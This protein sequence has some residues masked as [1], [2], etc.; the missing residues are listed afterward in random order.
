MTYTE[1]NFEEH[2]EKFFKSKSFNSY[3]SEEFYNKKFCLVP[4]D[5]FTFLEKT[6]TKKLDLLKKQYGDD[7]E[8]KFINYLYKEIDERGVI[9][10]L[11][12][13]I[14]N[15]GQKI[16][17]IYFEPNS[18]LNKDLE[19]KYKNNIFSIIRQLKFL[20][21]T[22]HSIDI[23]LFVNGLPIITIELKNSL[24]GQSAI[25]AVKQYIEDRNPNDKIFNFNRCIVHFAV[26][27]EEVFMTTAIKGKNTKFLPFNKDIENPIN[28]SGHKA[29]YLWEEVLTQN[30]ILN[31]IQ[32]Y[33]FIQEREEGS[34]DDKEIKYDLIFP[35]YHQ[36]NVINKIKSDIV[37]NDVGKKYLIQHTTGSGKSLTIAWLT[38]KLS[39]LF[40]SKDSLNKIFDTVIVLT[41][42][43]VLDKQLRNT[44][45]QLQQVEGVVNPVTKDSQEL[46]KFI[47]SGKNIIVSTIQKFPVI[48]SSINK[49]KNK[50]FAVVIDEVH[51]SQS[52][53]FSDHLVKSLSKN[54]L[55]NFEEGSPDDDLT[56]IDTYILNELSKLKDLSHISFFGFSGTP[57]KTTLEIFGTKN[58]ETGEIEAFHTYSMKQSIFEGFTL[59]VLKNYI[60]YERFFNISKKIEDEKILPTGKTKSLLVKYVDLHPSTIEEKT[61][62]IIDHFLNY[63]IKKINNTAKAMIVTRSRLHCVKYK[64]EFDK[65]LEKLGNPFKSLV[66]FT[67]KITDKDLEID[68]T[69][70]SMNGFADKITEEKFKDDDNKILIVNNKFQTGFDEPLLHTMYVD[71]KLSGIQSVQTLSRLN[72]SSKGKF[73]TTV[74][75]FVNNAAITKD[76]FQPYFQSLILSEETDPNEIYKIERNIRKF[77]IIDQQ[78]IDEY[79]KIYIDKKSKQELLQPILDTTIKN[80]KEA[81]NKEKK[82]EFKSLIHLFVKTYSFIKQISNFTDIDL[83]KFYIFVFDLLKK[84]PKK[85]NENYIVENF[86]DLNFLKISKKFQ[87]QIVLDD[88]DGTVRPGINTETTIKEEEFS[89]LDKIIDEINKRFNADFSDE[90]K[91]NLNDMQSDIKNNLNWLNIENDQTTETNK[92][93][94]FNKLFKEKIT[95]LASKNFSLYNKLQDEETKQIIKNKI[96]TEIN[97]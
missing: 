53:K 45:L 69:E 12:K 25:D 86:V 52:G 76:S 9:D 29:S 64:L 22:Q 73:D 46:K 80:F 56:D 85:D 7:F 65:Q 27:N 91:S 39:N 28:P 47:E 16:D 2:I 57:K 42:R 71:K 49:E 72:R 51:S 4:K 24:T 60:T 35:R 48:S 89:T 68:Y 20:E 62:I 55:D 1:R 54:D 43:K 96:Y 95:E 19:A 93:L 97:L 30:N 6:Q 3:K 63:S 58:K 41:D 44:I 11:R 92:R 84:I 88:T 34:K 33:V 77:N 94:I 79:C 40:K 26:G 8:E 18:G 74:L 14:K 59:D 90:D 15:S 50:K 82:Q 31:L 36:F 61:E 10:V 66:A 78:E 13:G 17:L 67:G 83:E 75:D 87:G 38:Y 70:S 37:I 5:L 32:N 21:D 23:V 81:L